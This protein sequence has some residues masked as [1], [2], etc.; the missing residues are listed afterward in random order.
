MLEF[1]KQGALPVV[2]CRNIREAMIDRFNP[3]LSAPLGLQPWQ[4]DQAVGCHQMADFDL[5]HANDAQA[6]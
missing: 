6:Q 3:K 2:I 5:P 1:N 4:G